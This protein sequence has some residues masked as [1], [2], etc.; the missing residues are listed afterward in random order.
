MDGCFGYGLIW[1]LV[2]LVLIIWIP[3]GILMFFIAG[4]VIMAA[5]FF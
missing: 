5:L 3:I 2:A 4:L 1:F